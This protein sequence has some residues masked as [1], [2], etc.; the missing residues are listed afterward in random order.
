MAGGAAHGGGA[1]REAPGAGLAESVNISSVR[2][3]YSDQHRASSD[4]PRPHR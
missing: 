2:P 1:G 3:K 4:Q